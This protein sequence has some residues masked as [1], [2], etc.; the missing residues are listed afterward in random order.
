MKNSEITQEIGAQLAKK[1][2]GFEF[3]SREKTLWRDTQKSSQRIQLTVVSTRVAG[4]KRMDASASVR[5]RELAKLCH[6]ND[7]PWPD[8]ARNWFWISIWCPSLI[9][10]FDRL[11]SFESTEKKLRRFIKDY[12][13]ALQK[14][15]VPWLDRYSIMEELFNGL[16]GDN[17]QDWIVGNAQRLPV[18]LAIHAKR[19][20]MDGFEKA[21]AEY[22]EYCDQP[23]ITNMERE[24]S[25]IIVAE[26]RRQFEE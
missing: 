2:E 20:D 17:Y 5:N 10:D 4:T 13:I 19:R 7:S 26:L 23:H 22:A 15:V 11:V 16:T 24:K 18:L 6:S 9:S 1:L 3:D 21:A 8:N 14:D 25:R 12:T